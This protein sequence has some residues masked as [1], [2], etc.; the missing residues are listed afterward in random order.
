MRGI[1]IGPQRSGATQRPDIPPARVG[2][3]LRIGCTGSEGDGL[4]PGA[5]GPGT[6]ELRALPPW[7]GSATAYLE[8]PAHPGG[9]GRVDNGTL[10]K[11]DGLNVAARTRDQE[12]GCG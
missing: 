10:G 8:L 6:G 7:S 3:V 2:A 4:V 5:G 1:G 9:S 11:L 12:C